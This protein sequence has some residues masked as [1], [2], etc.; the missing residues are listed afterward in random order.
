MII[1]DP[2][3]GSN[4]FSRRVS[5]VSGTAYNSPLYFTVV[6][7]Q[8]FGLDCSYAVLP[9]DAPGRLYLHALYCWSSTTKAT[10]VGAPAA[11]SI[12][13]NLAANHAAR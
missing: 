11:I 3:S 8:P 6:R 7:W 13:T 10:G 1:Y 5:G 4:H 12:D 2:A 9:G